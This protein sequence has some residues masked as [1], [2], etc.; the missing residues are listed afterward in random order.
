MNAK[1]RYVLLTT[2]ASCRSYFNE[3]IESNDIVIPI[4]PEALHLVTTHNLKH[5]RFADLVPMHDAKLQQRKNRD[6]IAAIREELN[7]ISR[8]FNEEIEIGNYFYFQL[9]VT[10]WPLLNDERACGIISSLIGTD[11]LLVFLPKKHKTFMSYR[12]EPGET[13]PMLLLENQNTLNLKIEFKTTNKTFSFWDDKVK[14]FRENL[15]RRL[16]HTLKWT[17]DVYR[18]RNKSP[19]KNNLL[20]I[21][22][23]Y[24]WLNV[25]KDTSFQ[26][27][28]KVNP[29]PLKI[30]FKLQLPKRRRQLLKPIINVFRKRL[31]GTISAEAGL[32]SSLAGAIASRI[33]QFSEIL[34]DVDDVVLKHDAI[35]SSVICY[36]EE[37]FV[38]HRANQNN[39]PVLIWQH[40]EKGFLHDI[41]DEEFDLACEF[42]HATTYLT[43]GDAVA[44][45][46]KFRLNTNHLK[47][48]KVVGSIG[49]RV[50]S[51]DKKPFILYATGKWTYSAFNDDMS[52]DP[53]FRQYNCQ[54]RII[55]LFENSKFGKQL[56]IKANNSFGLNYIP[57]RKNTHIKIEQNRPFTELLPS[58]EAVILD[59]PATTLI[60]AASLNVPI[61][62]LGGRRKEYT[63]SF[64]KDVGERVSW[65]ETLDDLEKSLEVY[66]TA[67]V[68]SA[69][70]REISVFGRYLLPSPKE[71]V[72]H[73]VIE[74][75]HEDINDR[76]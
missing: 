47:K 19:A 65:H 5:V 64:L 74:A 72:I 34:D 54:R 1:K 59:T 18:L 7:S 35:I 11:Q 37:A 31:A 40:G 55:K 23:G 16:F 61:F 46:Y 50:N 17:R 66:L 58:A 28:F 45:L 43:Y 4:G 63:Q 38:A 24:D 39:K 29:I 21:G 75:L 20:L 33:V 10:L 32:I 30:S 26:Q 56:I 49:K 44:D 69:D 52:I 8:A 62:V 70:F 15:P 57:H 13:L 27:Q 22:A 71:Q 36:P 67:G 2:A 60:E 41:V 6:K 25:A 9:I 73:R 12:L 3:N 14:N 53:D 76:L 68:Y 48:I 51:E 42:F